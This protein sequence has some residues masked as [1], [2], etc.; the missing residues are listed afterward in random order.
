MEKTKLHESQYAS[1]LIKDRLDHLKISSSAPMN[2][3][4]K[5]LHLEDSVKDSELIL[6]ALESGA[7][8]YEYFLVDDQKNFL[9]ILKTEDIDIILSDFSLPNYNGNEALKVSR[10]KYPNLP[11]LFVSGKI[12]EDAAIGT[13]LNGATD[14]VLKDKLVRLVPAI[15]R[16]IH[17]YDLEIKRKKA[18]SELI[19]AN[20]ELAFQN[21]EKEKR[22]AELNIA[23]KEFVFQNNEKEK[24]AKELILANQELAFQNDEKEK[25]A[26]EL[27]IANRELIFQNKEKEKRAAELFVANK[28]LDFQNKEKEK[29]AAELIIANKELAFQNDEKEKRA[30]E[31]IIANKEL[32]FQN[33]E[34]EKR[35]AELIIANKE[36]A[37]QNDEKEKR[38]AELIIANKEL[39]FQNDEKENRE[40]ELIIANKELLFQNQEK[41]KRADELTLANKELVFQNEE[42]EKRAAELVIANKELVF[43]TG[44]KKKRAA[45]LV[46]ADKELVFQNEEK[47]KRAEELI[48]SDNELVYQ[49]GE[50]EK[51]EIANIE[52]E[53]ISKSLKLA[54]QYSLSLIEASRDPLITINPAGKITDMN[55]ALTQITGLTRHEL[56]GTDFLDYFTEPEMAREVYEEVFAKGSVAD[57]PLTLRHKDGKLTDVLFNGSV[58]KDENGKVLGVVIVARDVTAQKLLSKYSLSLIEASLDPLITISTEGK[59]TDMNE[60]LVNI[61][62][63]TRDELTGTDFF[64]YF[65][66]P[67]MARDVYLEVFANGSVAD[68]PLTLRHKNGKLTDVLFNGSV[69]K[70]DRGNVLGVVIVARDVTEQKR[71]AGELTEAIVFAE[72][73][74][75]IAEEAKSKAEEATRVAENAVKSKQQFLSNM[76][77]EIRTPMNAIIGFTKVLLKTD[78]SV[79]QKEYLQAIKMSGDA[80]IVLINDILDLA[81][82]DAGKMIF[83]QIPFKMAVSLA[84][85]LHLFESKIREKNIVLIKEYDGKIP[86][87]LVGDPVRLHQIILNLV[88]NAVKFT[89]KGKIVVSVRLIDEDENNVTIEFSVK[90]TGIGISEEKIC[91]IFENF[92]QASSGTSRLYGG[93]GL[94][95]AI[96]KQLVEAQ[97]GTISVTSKIDVGSTFGFVLSFPKTKADAQ[98]DLGVMELDPDIKDIKVL[99]VEDIP[100]NQLLMKTLLDDFGFERDIA[101]NGKIAIEKLKT[102]TYDIILMDLQMPE[103]NGFEATDYIRHTMNSNIPIIALTADVTTVDLEKC[104]FVGMDDYISKP[105]DEKLLYSKIVGLVKKNVP[106]KEVVV[107]AISEVIKLKRTDLQY[108]IQ[109]TK[110]N[111]VLMMEMISLYLA[112]TP[113]LIDAMKKGMQEK[114]WKTLYS[115]VHKMIPSFS[116]MG[117]HVDFENMA[118]KVQEYAST[119]LQLDGIPEMVNQLETVCSQACEELQEEYT[120]IKNRKQ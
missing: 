104:R 67:E 33:D 59:I 28:E 82:V 99:V 103:M 94:G 75:G 37:F 23:N 98:L 56:T 24:R 42:K 1:N 68:S 13:M 69:Y 26:D 96:V 8:K 106:A 91:K 105:V 108:L 25:R 3:K 115:A 17:E 12:G 7:I 57:S 49:I 100:L 84:A 46:I 2:K 5:I 66:D 21:D 107:E 29:R 77:H 47:E 79:R 45:E 86:E 39:A 80:L 38:A 89:N 40:A 54:S 113:P 118:K 64:D 61:T 111:P 93:T 76:S 101:D 117:I 6:T 65:T 16:A 27:I 74:V 58:Y 83:E 71:I 15:K 110:S 87:V 60:A 62:G 55:E 97:G 36:L 52:L 51:G 35:A 112:Q 73:A 14:Y 119:Q 30:A 4:I 10:E 116:I 34:K 43:Q 32:A 78:F 22:E 53:A 18:E 20:K 11:F 41:G 120:K 85:M 31:L 70:D 72:L 90:D 44:E 63:M 48:L 102:N 50:K 9:N 19:I 109:R 114:D 88:S 81:K 92:Q 95:L